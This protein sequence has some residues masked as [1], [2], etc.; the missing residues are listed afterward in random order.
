MVLEWSQNDTEMTLERR[1]YQTII[2]FDKGD[3]FLPSNESNESNDLINKPVLV[4][5][6]IKQAEISYIQSF[7]LH[8]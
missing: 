1:L 6:F 2:T 5:S 4:T 7:P 8:I 3:P